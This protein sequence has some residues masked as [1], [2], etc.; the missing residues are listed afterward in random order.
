MTWR[1]APPQLPAAAGRYTVP[2]VAAISRTTTVDTE[3]ALAM[4]SGLAQT[5]RLAIFRL[6]VEHAP[7]GLAASEIGERLGMANATLSFHLK[8]LTHA[9]L[10]RRRP[11]GRHVY[12][13]AAVD[14]MRELLGFLLENCC[15]GAP[16]EA[17]G[18]PC[19]D[20]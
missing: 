7:D 2:M 14:A 16:C 6:L 17:V 9:G 3:Q 12:Y 15:G 8:E 4:L 5:S 18:G 1:A 13:A 20:A 11:S 10:V 19:G